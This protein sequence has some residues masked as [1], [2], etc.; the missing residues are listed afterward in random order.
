[1]ETEWRIARAQ[2]RELLQDNGQASHR[3]LAEATGYSVSWVRKWR[4]R[5]TQAPPSDEQ[6][7]N[8][9]SHRPRHMPRQVSVEVEERIIA[10]RV[11]L[12]EQYHRTVGPRTIA[13]YL[14]HHAAEGRA[15]GPTSSATIW[16]IL[17]KR[18]YIL[19]PVRHDPQ[20]V[21]RPEPGVHWE[22]DFCTAAKVSPEAP[23]KQ[24]H[25]LEVLSVIDRGSSACMD[26]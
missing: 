25:G 8:G 2:L 3:E 26:S 1:M 14:K 7:L 17:R 24:Q 21:K 23:N 10:L 22:I 18:Q 13:A 11:A 20:P 4:K 15:W 19:D 6:V 12:S 5:L 9:Q 16:R